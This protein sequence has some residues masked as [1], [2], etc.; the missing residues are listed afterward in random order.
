MAKFTKTLF[1]RSSPI[2]GIALSI[3]LTLLQII[4][5]RYI[6]EKQLKI[7]KT[8]FKDA[9]KGGLFGHFG[10]GKKKL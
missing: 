9:F 10:F 2:W 1:K 7:T 3:G 4:G 6:R 8:D 5:S